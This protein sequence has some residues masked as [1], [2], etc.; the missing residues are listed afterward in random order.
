MWYAHFSSIP[1]DILNLTLQKYRLPMFTDFQNINRL[2]NPPAQLLHRLQLKSEVCQN[3]RQK[4][5]FK[6]GTKTK[7]VLKRILQNIC[8]G[9]CTN[10]ASPSKESFQTIYFGEKDKMENWRC[11]LLP[12]RQRWEGIARLVLIIRNGV[13]F[14]FFQ[15]FML[16]REVCLFTT[17]RESWMKSNS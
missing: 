16:T 10:S 15:F 5:G 12:L 17:T 7:T 9:P 14:S 1:C 4:Y 6:T 8:H 11:A 13:K 2:Y 3:E